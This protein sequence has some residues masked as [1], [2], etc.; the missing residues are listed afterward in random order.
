MVEIIAEIAQAHEG[1]LG[2]LHSYIDALAKTGINTVKFQ[3]HIADA[4]SSEFEPFRVN[5]SYVDKRRIDY[6]RRM[7]FTEEQWIGIKEHCDKVGLEFLSSPFSIE[8]FDLLERLGVK[9]YKIAS[10][11]VSNFLLLEKIKATRKPVLLSS[12]M[13]SMYEIEKAFNFLRPEISEIS[14]FQCTTA[15]PTPPEQYG[16]NV[17]AELK[18]RFKCDVGLSD[19]S[20]DIYSSIAAVVLGAKFIEVHATFSKQIFGPDTSSSLTMEQMTEMTR[21]I[22]LIDRALANPVNKNENEKYDDLKKMFGKSLALR[23][24][25]ALGEVITE[26]HLEAKKPGGKGIPAEDFKKIIGKR[27]NKEIPKYAFINLEDINFG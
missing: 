18:T 8:A 17:I 16:L 2:I 22:R 5:F 15:Y 6:W 27:V 1:S 26:A 12:G 20:G 14:V 23:K 24:N 19:H 25:I 13:S 4:E 10:G 3:T 11:E 9:R 7:E 21:A